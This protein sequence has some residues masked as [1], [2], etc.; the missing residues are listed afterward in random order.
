MIPDKKKFILLG[1]TP[2]PP[3]VGWKRRGTLHWW[4][5]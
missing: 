5:L 2:A 1:S 4:F 3:A